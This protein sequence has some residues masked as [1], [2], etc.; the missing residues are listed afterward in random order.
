ME[1]EHNVKR[2]PTIVFLVDGMAALSLARLQMRIGLNPDAP[3]PEWFSRIDAFSARIRRLPRD[4]EIA[5][6]FI[7]DETRLAEIA[8]LVGFLDSV[9]L[10]LILPE[11]NAVLRR[12]ARLLHPSYVLSPDGDFKDLTAVLD[13]IQ[14][15][16][17]PST[18]MEA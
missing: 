7:A 11:E 13:K 16:N 15:N 17:K 9:R 14:I 3:A 8:D 18:Q 10:I 6:L 2:N 5:V 1:T 12:E 4:I